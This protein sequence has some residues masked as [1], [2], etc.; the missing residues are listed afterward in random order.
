MLSATKAAELIAARELSSEELVTACLD[1]IASREHD[2]WAWAYV[3]AEQA[4]A[5]ARERDAES[6][7]GPLHGIPVGVKDVIDTADMQTRYGSPIYEGHV[8]A[9]DAP[10]VTWLREQ[11]AVILGKTITTEFATYDP[12]P[13]ANPLDVTRTPGGSSAGSAAAVADG[14]VPLAYGTQTAGSTIR[15]ASFCGVAG[16]K[17]T[18][19]WRSVEGVKRL[20]ERLDALG[21]LGPTVA[22]AAMLGGWQAPAPREARIAVCRTPWW[23]RLEDAGRAAIEEAAARLGADEVELPEEFAG[24]P[25][26]H[27]LVMAFDIAR[28]LEPEWRDHAS[29]LSGALRDYIEE[30]RRVEAGAVEAAVA[31]ADRCR[32]A[33][34]EVL[35]GRDALLVPAALGEA[36]VGRATGDPLPCRAWT[37]LGTPAISVP[38]LSGPAGMPI[39]VQLVGL[40]GGEEELLGAAAWVE[41]ALG[42]A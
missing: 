32:A 2:L 35:A 40:A 41:K 22:D 38:G 8:P 36:P 20:S 10:C 15:P 1:R 21:L 11:G 29:E 7:R 33:L 16:V 30:G 14:M 4:L 9:R 28:N 5:Q 34:P 25:R 42:G 6:P 17:P 13:T 31:L 27:E 12:P 23:D 37:L 39:G 3:D 26:A 18:H 19:G 24:L